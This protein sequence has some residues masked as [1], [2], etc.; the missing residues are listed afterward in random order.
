M[1]PGSHP[2]LASCNSTGL[3]TFEFAPSARS[4]RSV[5]EHWGFN[6]ARRDPRLPSSP[7]KPHPRSTSRLPFTSASSQASSKT[8]LSKSRIPSSFT[9]TSRLSRLSSHARCLCRGTRDS[10]SPNPLLGSSRANGSYPGI[11]ALNAPGA[12]RRAPARVDRAPTDLSLP[13]D[14]S[15]KPPAPERP[16]QVPVRS[17][18]TSLRPPRP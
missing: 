16:G 11:V 8:R 3:A 5:P 4:S 17:T 6:S 15:L 10:G 13:G 7:G 12:D 18:V 1:P 14:Y 2:T 9:L